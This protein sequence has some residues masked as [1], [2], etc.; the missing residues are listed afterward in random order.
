MVAVWVLTVSAFSYDN[1]E[2][3]KSFASNVGADV[4]SLASGGILV[5]YEPPAEA[6]PDEMLTDKAAIKIAAVSLR[7]F[8]DAG[9]R[10][11]FTWFGKERSRTI[12]RGELERWIA[13]RRVPLKCQ[14]EESA[15]IERRMARLADGGGK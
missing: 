5:K 9:H 3:L 11:E 7:V 4:L 15:D 1:L 2:S 12:R 13:S 8:R 6:D 10:G 14:G